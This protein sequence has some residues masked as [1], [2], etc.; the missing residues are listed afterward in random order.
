MNYNFDEIID[1]RNTNA[2]NTDGWRRYI[3]K[4]NWEQ[5]FPYKDEEFVRMWVADMEFATPEPVLAGIRKRLDRQILGYTTLSTEDYYNDLSAWYQQ[6]YQWDFPKEELVITEGVVPALFRAV[7]DLV[8]PGEKVLILTPSYGP[9]AKAVKANGCQ[10]VMSKLQQDENG[11]FRMDYDDLAA[12]VADPDVKLML[13]CNPHNPTGRVWTKDELERLARI[14]EATDLWVVSDEI[15][16]DLVRTGLAHIPLG[17]IMPQY[18]KLITCMSASK[19]FNLA[20][21]MMANAI[22]R[23]PAERRKF[24]AGN[25]GGGGIN[26]LSLAAHQAAYEQGGEWLTQLKTYLDENFRFVQEYFAQELPEVVCGIPEATYLD[27]VDFRN[28]FPDGDGNFDG[29]DLTLFFAEQAGVLLEG[30]DKLFVD[31]AEGFVRLNLAMPRSLVATGVERMVQAVK[32]CN[33]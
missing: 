27:W 9:F 17:K 29:R 5:E 31:N 26:P 28:C 4:E 12:K 3:F 23:D 18:Q 33:S 20:G 32:G 11:T 16:C 13:F 25:K 7:E 24:K 14:I 21:M 6:R 2:L 19:T 10:L 22:I 8:K 30:G 1:R 15:H